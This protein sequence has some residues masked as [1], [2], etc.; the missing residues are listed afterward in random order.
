MWVSKHQNFSVAEIESMINLC[1][2]F[3]NSCCNDLPLKS[4]NKK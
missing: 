1:F 2:N 3:K 4:H